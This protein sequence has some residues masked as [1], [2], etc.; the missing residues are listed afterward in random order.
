[1][2]QAL[3]LSPIRAS[4]QINDYIAHRVHVVGLGCEASFYVRPDPAPRPGYPPQP[5]TLDECHGFTRE[6]CDGFAAEIARTYPD[7]RDRTHALLTDALGRFA[8]S[9]AEAVRADPGSAVSAR[10]LPGRACMEVVFSPSDVHLIDLDVFEELAGAST[11]NLC[12]VELSPYGFGLHFPRLDVDLSVPMLRR[13]RFER[14]PG[15]G[16]EAA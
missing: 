10:Y 2:A 12:D 16:S 7:L 3:A 13:R 9:R 6:Q 14:A 4:T 5:V 8:A 11:A 1:M 15:E